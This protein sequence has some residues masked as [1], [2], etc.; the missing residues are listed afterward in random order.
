MIRFVRSQLVFITLGVLAGLFIAPAVVLSW[1]GLQTMYDRAFPV[2]EMV[3]Q[4]E[5]ADRQEIVISIIGDKNRTCEYVRVQAFVRDPTGQLRDAYMERIDRRPTNATKLPG[6]YYAG[7]WRIWPRGDAVGAV[8]DI[9][10][11][12]GDRLV[13]TRIADVQ[14]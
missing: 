3:G 9:H 4:V 10:H 1:H 13:V 12:C 14:L 2:V 5:H 6:T 11:L 7:T 8:V